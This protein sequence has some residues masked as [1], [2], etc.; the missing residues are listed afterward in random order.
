MGEG[1]SFDFGKFANKFQKI[2]KKQ[3]ESHFNI[4]NNESGQLRI[5][6]RDEDQIEGMDAADAE[7]PMESM[8]DPAIP[9]GPGCNPHGVIK[10]YDPVKGY[11]FIICAGLSED[12]Y[13]PRT[14]LPTNFQGKSQKDMPNL[15]G[16]Q[17]SFDLIPNSEKGPRAEHASLLLKWHNEDRCWLLKRDVDP[18]VD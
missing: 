10:S 6:L 14:A 12:I 15:A 18:T 9:L 11:G 16:V 17:V 3:L 13:M 2:K 4:Q 5:E 1:G 7:E 8:E